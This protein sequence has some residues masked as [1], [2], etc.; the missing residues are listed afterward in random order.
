MTNVPR[1]RRYLRFWRP[2]PA[3]GVA[4][5]AQAAYDNAE[6][7]RYSARIARM[8]SSRAA[9]L[10]GTSIAAIDTTR[11]TPAAAM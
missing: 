9:R 6:E 4:F 8:G 7:R 2:D 5:P 10:A 3:N 11:S 1:W